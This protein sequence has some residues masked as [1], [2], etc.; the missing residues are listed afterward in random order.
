MDIA[1][2]QR[3][4]NR[5]AALLRATANDLKRNDAAAERD[6][7]LP[8]GS[9]AAYAAG[10]RPISWQ[11]ISQAARAWPVNE[12]DLLPIHDDCPTGVRICRPEESLATSRVIERGSVP[13]YE[14]RDTAMSRVASYRP[15]WI[16]M[17]W[18]V[19][20]DDPDNASVQWNNGHLLYQFTYFVGPVNYYFEWAGRRYCV[21]MRTGDSVWGLP[22]V[23]HSFTARGTGEP[24]YI[25]ALTYGGGLTGDVQRELAVLGAE[26]ARALAIDALADDD[27]APAAEVLGSH[28]RAR[29]L[30][31]QRLS[32]RAGIGLDRL[33]A[34]LAGRARTTGAER[35]ALAHA[36]RINI[37]ELQPAGSRARTGAAVRRRAAAQR[38]PYPS[39]DPAYE[40]I[41][42]AGDP[43]HP[44]TTAV[45]LRVRRAEPAEPLQTYQH[46]YLYVL[47][48]ADA[49]LHWQHGEVRHTARLEP[50]ASAY[51]SPHVPIAFTPARPGAEPAILVLRIAEKV[52]T[53]TRFLLGAMA[54]GGIDRYLSEDRLWYEEKGGAGAFVHT[55]RALH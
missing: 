54:A 24:A 50:G 55:E 21:P 47:P 2:D 5:A 53:E 46:Q 4:L 45:E 6:L 13:Y 52:G 8:P 18:S 42:L 29:M 43:L 28:M 49:I 35:A 44:H 30:T 22:F 7:G 26:A 1:G 20:D 25:L 33:E 19:D 16:R 3:Y 41:E 37:R 27:A 34:L 11:L 32:E 12:R 14:Y 39:G 9:F 48:A 15:E 23:P 17:L 38:W 31:A 36:L 10:S 51:V 40:V